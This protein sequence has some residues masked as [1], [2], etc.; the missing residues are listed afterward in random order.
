MWDLKDCDDS[1]LIQLVTFWSLFMVLCFI[2]TK[3][4]GVWIP[5]PSSGKSLLNLAQSIKLV[6]ITGHQHQHKTYYIDQ[7]QHQPSAGVKTN[8]KISPHT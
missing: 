5:S 8:I 1:T 6:H 4:F 2:Y 3:H 7:T